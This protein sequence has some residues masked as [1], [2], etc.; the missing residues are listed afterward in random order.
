MNQNPHDYDALVAKV[1][2]GETIADD[3]YAALLAHPE[4]GPLLES[5]DTIMA[6]SAS[7]DDSAMPAWDKQVLCDE[8]A[9]HHAKPQSGW[10]SHW[11]E[12]LSVL[13][14]AC[15]FV[16]VALVTLNVSIHQ[17]EHGTVVRFNDTG[18]APDT[19]SAMMDEK[20]AQ[21]QAKDAQMLSTYLASYHQSQ[22]ESTLDM[23]NYLVE[24]ARKERKEDIG[25]LIQYINEQRMDDRQAVAHQLRVLENDILGQTGTPVRQY[26]ITEIE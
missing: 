3:A 4:Y 13:S 12:G 6:K 20:I 19:V 25:E 7:Y 10:L 21:Y 15:S 5:H 23:V 2:A 9:K 1:L 14:L 26:P 11:K 8:F 24:S 22:Q 18:L 17:N 16:A